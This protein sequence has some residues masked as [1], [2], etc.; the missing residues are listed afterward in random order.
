MVINAVGKIKCDRHKMACGGREGGA[1]LNCV[2]REDLPEQ[3]HL[4]RQPCDHQGQSIPGIH[5][6]IQKK[7]MDT[8]LVT[9]LLA[10]SGKG[11][12]T[13]VGEDNRFYSLI[14]I[15]LFEYFTCIIFQN[16]LC[17]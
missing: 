7:G 14:Y 8:Y 16:Y 10:T 5:L 1:N 2:T 3:W 13:R 9:C 15:L 12:H 6:H 4:K 11:W 17:L